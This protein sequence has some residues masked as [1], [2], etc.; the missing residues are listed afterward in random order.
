MTTPYD[1]LKKLMKESTH[2]EMECRV[3]LENTKEKLV[4]NPP[5][6]FVRFEPEYRGHTGDS[7]LIITCEVENDAGI[8]CVEAYI[9]EVKAPQCYVFEF[10]NDNR[11]K[12]TKDL[13]S[14]E[15]Q[16]LHYYEEYKKSETFKQE[17]GITSSD[18]IHIGGIIIGQ[19]DRLVKPNKKYDSTEKKNSLYTRAINCRKEHFYKA[20]R[21]DFIIWDRIL[22]LLRSDQS[23]SQQSEEVSAISSK[24]NN[25]DVSVNV[26]NDEPN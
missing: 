9:W 10:D 3:Y 2:K 1:C 20:S 23:L 5:D 6:K 17:F 25:F 14:A 22:D 12:P 21:I 26:N 19:K 24:S 8:R 4:K 7:D 16:L 15:N 18:N 13:I 11:V